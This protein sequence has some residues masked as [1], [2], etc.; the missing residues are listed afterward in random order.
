MVIHV[1][2]KSAEPLLT[3]TQVAIAIAGFAGIIG[4]FQFKEGERI[5]W[6]D[7]VGLGMIVNTCLMAAFY[8]TLPLLLSNLGISDEFVWAI[9]SG[10]GTAIYTIFMLYVFPTVTSSDLENHTGTRV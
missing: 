3:L 5:R 6:G 1:V 7:A 9:G 2:Y 4:T 10:S 8:S